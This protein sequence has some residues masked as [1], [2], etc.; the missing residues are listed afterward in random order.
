MSKSIESAIEEASAWLDL[1]G[2]EFVGQGVHDGDD[3]IVVG[4]SLP[5]EAMREK[6]PRS[7]HGFAVTIQKSGTIHA[8]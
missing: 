5:V 8:E 4:T 3:C 7:F 2:V 6:L 1:D